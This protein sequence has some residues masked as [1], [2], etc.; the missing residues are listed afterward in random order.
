MKAEI[1]ELSARVEAV[2]M[3]RNEAVQQVQSQISRVAAHGSVPYSRI[4]QSAST[5][6]AALSQRNFYQ[7]MCN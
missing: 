6:T 1:Q 4:L 7:T 2:E 5:V 3:E